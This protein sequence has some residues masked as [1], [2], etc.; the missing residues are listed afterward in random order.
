MSKK[1]MKESFFSAK[2]IVAMAVGTALYAALT[3]PFNVFQIPGAGGLIAVRP[4]VAIPMLF[5]FVFGPI[6]GFVAGLLGNILSDFLSFGGFFWNWDIGNGLLGAIPG[7]AYFVIKRTDWTKAKT[8]LTAAVLAIVASI[9]GI[10]F[11]AMT[12][13]AFQIGLSTLGA[14][15]AEFYSAAGTD[16]IN[17]AILTPILLYAYATA[18]AGRA[19][20]V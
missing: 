17:G 3:I 9:V 6:T 16:A 7:I 12:D 19:R 20:R 4:T 1:G 11:A 15:L 2:Q 14:A 10:G 13:L 8:L 18:T 5:G